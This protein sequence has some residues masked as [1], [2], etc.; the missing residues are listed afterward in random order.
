MSSYRMR[1][2]HFRGYL[3]YLLGRD[4]ASWVILAH[5]LGAI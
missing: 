4:L 2:R 3:Y 5:Q 1:R